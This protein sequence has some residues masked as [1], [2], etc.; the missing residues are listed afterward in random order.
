MRRMERALQR[1]VLAVFGLGLTIVLAG[2]TAAPMIDG[3]PT[4][5]GLPAGTPERPATPYQYPAVHDMPP[6]RPTQPMS[7]EQLQNLENELAVV[8]DRQEAREGP[9]KKTGQTVKKKPTA[10]NTGQ[11]AGAKD[12]TKDGVKTNP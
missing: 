10:A 12:G 8:R 7:E 5:M 9:A 1:S 6:P 2:C 4:N 11:A 3:L